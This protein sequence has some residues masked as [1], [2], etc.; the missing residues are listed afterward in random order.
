MEEK[1]HGTVVLRLQEAVGSTRSISV[2]RVVQSLLLVGTLAVLLIAARAFGTVRGVGGLAEV[3]SSGNLVLFVCCVIL[4]VVVLT[5]II[6]AVWFANSQFGR[7][8][9]L[10]GSPMTVVVCDGTITICRDAYNSVFA[11]PSKAMEYN[12]GTESVKRI[13]FDLGTKELH[14]LVNNVTVTTSVNGVNKSRNCGNKKLVFNLSVQENPLLIISRLENALGV[15]LYR[16][17]TIGL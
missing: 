10:I 1:N 7:G 13:V 4:H 2:Y 14:F 11:G 17:I 6:V 3:F 15:K 9:T 12:F 5:L 16:T 8:I